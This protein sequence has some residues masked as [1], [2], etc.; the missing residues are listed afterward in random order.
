MK[1]I[2]DLD[3]GDIIYSYNFETESIEEVPILDTLFVAL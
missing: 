2:Y 1:S 3:D